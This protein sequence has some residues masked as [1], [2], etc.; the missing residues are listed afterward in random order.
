MPLK[1][2]LLP[3]KNLAVAEGEV[4]AFLRPHGVLAVKK[5]FMADGENTF[6]R[7]GCSAIGCK[8]VFICVHLW[9]NCRF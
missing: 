5:E 8:S 7:R 9:L 2:F 3:V 4:N 1:L 6:W